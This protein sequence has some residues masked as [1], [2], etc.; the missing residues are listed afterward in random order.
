MIKKIETIYDLYMACRHLSEFIGNP[1]SDLKN[2]LDDKTYENGWYW[3]DEKE[4]LFSPLIVLSEPG[5]DLIY[6][7][8][9]SMTEDDCY[10]TMKYVDF[11]FGQTFYLEGHQD[12]SKENI[13]NDYIFKNDLA[14]C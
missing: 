11:M 6:I 1:I 7:M 4:E 14:K 2:L 9:E 3:D 5:Y 10:P 13:F 12:Y 8:K